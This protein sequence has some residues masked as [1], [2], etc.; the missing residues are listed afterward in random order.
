M[1]THTAPSTGATEINRSAPETSG[2]AR[3]VPARVAT[4]DFRAVLAAAFD[5]LG[6]S[7]SAQTAFERTKDFYRAGGADWT[8]TLG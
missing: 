7:A 6:V 2:L 8:R 5:R 3:G 1:N 4:P